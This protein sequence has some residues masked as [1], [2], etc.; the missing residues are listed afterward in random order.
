VLA[1]VVQQSNSTLP[2]VPS[3]NGK[4]QHFL[5]NQTWKKNP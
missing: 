4:S 5:H 3:W 1:F 2:F